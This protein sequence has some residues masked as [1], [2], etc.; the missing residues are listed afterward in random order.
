MPPLTKRPRT[1][2][3][4]LDAFG[5]LYRPR[6]SIAVQYLAVAKSCGL[7]LDTDTDHFSQSF[8]NAF[9]A[10]YSRSPNYGKATGMKPEKWWANVVNETF[11]PLVLPGE[12]IPGSLS[13]SL[14]Q[15][16]SSHKGYE[17]FPD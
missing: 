6:Q 16:F 17:L 2:L 10:N 3:I 12:A 1:L 15:H 11:K 14:F 5:T 7:D 4:T 9:K 8:K 13:D